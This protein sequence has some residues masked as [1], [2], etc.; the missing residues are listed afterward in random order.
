[1]DDYVVIAQS[2]K[3]QARRTLVL[4]FSTAGGGTQP[5]LTWAVSS[6]EPSTTATPCD[7]KLELNPSLGTQTNPEKSSRKRK[8]SAVDVSRRTERPLR[9]RRVHGAPAHAPGAVKSELTSSSV[10]T[11]NSVDGSTDT[12]SA[13]EPKLEPKSAE[14]LDAETIGQKLEDSASVELVAPRTDA[15]D[16]LAAIAVL[17]APGENTENKEPCV[18]VK[19]NPPDDTGLIP[20]VKRHGSA[21]QF[22]STVLYNLL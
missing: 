18:P 4:A 2:P 11:S 12:P 15:L 10:V 1:M 21:T 22:C 17:R 9:T 16:L 7:E 8:A 13:V 14:C 3:A 6:A 19:L 20:L 5:D